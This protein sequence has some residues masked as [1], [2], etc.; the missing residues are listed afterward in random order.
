MHRRI[1]RGPERLQRHSRHAI[2]AALVF[3][4][5]SFAGF[6]WRAASLG[7]WLR[8]PLYAD[9]AERL[10]ERIAAKTAN[11]VKPLSIVMFGSSRTSNAL[12][13]TDLETAL[14]KGTERP[15]VAFNLGIP[16]SG[17]VTQLLYLRRIFSEGIRPDLVLFEIMP[18]LLAGQVDEPI[19]QHFFAPERLLPGE[20]EF[21]VA[22]SYP[23]DKFVEGER[24]ATR[25]PLYGMR[26]PIRGRYLPAWSPWNMRCDSSRNSDETGWMRPVFDPVTDEQYE[27]GVAWARQEYADL[28]FTLLLHGPACA[29]V[30]E[31]I[32]ACRNAGVPIGLVLMPEGT[33]FRAMYTPRALAELD[34]F[35]RRQQCPVIDA[36]LWLADDGFSDSHH[37]V[38]S[39]ARE[40]TRR[41][42]QAIVERELV[43]LR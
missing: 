14:E 42:G 33:D 5:V 24:L 25:F 17:P 19:E 41:L 29:A 26:L 1:D 39:G 43:G 32:G 21:V 11:G 6:A 31:S 34:A 30:E 16:S 2:L 36:R 22:H 3:V 9:K 23:A 18:P 40:F 20:A 7:A 35:M 38:S 13:G 8:D 27:R 4:V 37:M 12:R 15:V 10:I 28:L